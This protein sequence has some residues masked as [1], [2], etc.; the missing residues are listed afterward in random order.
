MK[1]VS[2]S[3]ALLAICSCKPN[4]GSILS[5][6][7]D[8][9]DKRPAYIVYKGEVV[10]GTIVF[11]WESE[12]LSPSSINRV[13]KGGR[14]SL[15]IRTEDTTGNEAQATVE[16]FDGVTNVF[17]LPSEGRRFKWVPANQ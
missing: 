12:Y 14:H 1:I 10:L 16:C 15:S 9:F 13:S 17:P 3:C 8:L 11:D 6:K 2:L 4:G 5:C 7:S